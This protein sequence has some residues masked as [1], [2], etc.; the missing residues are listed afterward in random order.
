MV[1]SGPFEK[2]IRVTMIL[3]LTGPQYSGKVAE[4]CV[5]IWKSLG[6]YTDAE[7]KAIEQFIDAFKDENFPPGASILFTLSPTGSL[8]VSNILF[9]DY[10][11]ILLNHS[12]E[13]TCDCL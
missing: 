6:L 12:N 2:F 3:P 8:T 5:A 4:N 9:K 11:Q 1:F 13:T 10:N 7:S